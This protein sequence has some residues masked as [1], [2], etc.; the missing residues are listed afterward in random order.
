[1][2]FLTNK[3]YTMID[4]WRS[5]NVSNPCAPQF[6]TSLDLLKTW[7]DA[8]EQYLYKM[9]GNK[10]ILTKENISYNKSISAMRK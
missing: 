4:K 6:A 9:L 1:M 10:T 8:K 2:I 3:E 7:S 5:I